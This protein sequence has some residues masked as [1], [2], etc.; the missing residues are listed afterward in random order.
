MQKEI[1]KEIKAEII[2]LM[3]EDISEFSRLICADVVTD[4][5][6]EFHHE[7]YNLA[8][9]NEKVV[10]AAP[11]G[12]AKST[13]LG[14]IYPLWVALFKRR[15]D[16]M[17]VSSS[18]GLAT[19]HLRYIK[20]AIEANPLIKEIWGD[21]KSEKWTESHIVLRHSDGKLINI[22]AKGAGGQIRGYRPDCI[23]IDDLET[24]DSVESEEQRKKLKDWLFKA[25][26]NCMLPGG[27]ILIIG[28]VLS[29]LSL[30]NDLLESPNGWAKKRYTAYV[31]GVQEEGHELWPEKRPHEWLKQRKA[32]IGSHRFSAE[33]MNDPVSDE[34]A[35][36][37]AEQIRFWE[38][39]PD[40]LNCVITVDP[41]YSEDVKAD[42]KVAALVGIDHKNNRYLMHYI[43]THSST[44]EFMQSI[45]NLYRSNRDRVISLGIPSGGTER[46]FYRSFLNKADEAGLYPPIVGL[47]NTFTTVTGGSVR[48]KKARI[49]ASLQ[50]LFENGRYFI[51]KDHHEARD[52][53]LTIGNS[54]WD[55]LVD[56]MAYAEQI[57]Q[58]HFIDPNKDVEI[59]RYGEKKYKKSYDFSRANNYGMDL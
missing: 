34:M 12:F 45:L 51:G 58:P 19:E 22:R 48:S 43:R 30:L 44:G 49:I 29:Q 54:R 4:D 27:Q 57:L 50:P 15:K 17:I 56:A 59:G 26:F 1:T 41:A 25:C 40:Q 14:R 23:I 31:D 10:V 28:T 32:E 5:I 18:E 2:Q 13:L 52:E 38:E 6:P 46:E 39:L 47:K 37:K 36:I 8:V 11:R 3:A 33:Y 42:Y 35:P 16:I 24:D 20:S 55:D 21:L 53:L 7:L 9:Y